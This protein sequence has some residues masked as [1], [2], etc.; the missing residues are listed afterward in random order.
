MKQL[1]KEAGLTQVEIAEKFNKKKQDVNRWFNGRITPNV[2]IV[3]KLS[4]MLNVSMEELTKKL[5][6]IK[7]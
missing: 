6:E 3:K 7:K 4:E 1:I 2:F 5:K